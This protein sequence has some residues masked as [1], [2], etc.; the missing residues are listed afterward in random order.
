MNRRKL[1]LVIA[2]LFVFVLLFAPTAQAGS[3]T[4]VTLVDSN[5]SAK[6]KADPDSHKRACAIKCAKSGYGILTA[7][8]K[9]VKFDADGSA[10]ALALLEKSDKVDKLRVDVNGEIEGETLKVATIA[11]TS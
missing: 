3:W 8:G 6:V 9:F 11:F 2:A 1:G 10:K 5:C 4:N 7:D